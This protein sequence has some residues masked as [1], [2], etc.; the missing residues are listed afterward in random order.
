MRLLSLVDVSPDPVSSFGIVGL[1]VFALIVCAVS[2]ALII[3]FV[4]LLKRRSRRQSNAQ[5]NEVENQQYAA[6]QSTR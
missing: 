2:I 1:V 5:V 4:F 6:H 3:G